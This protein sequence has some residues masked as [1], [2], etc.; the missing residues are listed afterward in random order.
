[1]KPQNEIVNRYCQIAEGLRQM[2][3]D[4]I[5]QYGVGM[6]EEHSKQFRYW[7]AY[8]NIR[9]KTL[10]L[11]RLTEGVLRVPPDE[12]NDMAKA[13]LIDDY[14]DIANYAIMAVQILENKDEIRSDSDA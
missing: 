12:L 7:A 14:K 13:K 3:C 5:S 9:R 8:F 11:E 6:Y 2:F 1:M 10:R 4:K